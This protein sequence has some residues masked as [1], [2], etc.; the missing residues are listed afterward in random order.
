[1]SKVFFLIPVFVGLMAFVA[2]A[3]GSFQVENFLSN[4]HLGRDRG[5]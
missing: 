2:A 4:S 3:Q 1:M 5:M